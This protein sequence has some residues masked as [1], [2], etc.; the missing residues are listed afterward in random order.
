MGK[1]LFISCT[2]VG[3]AM[4]NEI[5][6]YEDIKETKVVGVV[7]L[8][9]RRGVHK[10]NYHSYFDIQNDYNIPVYYCNNVNDED[11]IQFM[12]N[13]NPDIIIQSGWSQKFSS[14]VLDIPRYKCIGEHPSPLPK[15]R[16]AACLNWAIINNETLW[17][18]SFF[19]MVDEYD[20]GELYAHR[21]FEI[22]KHDYIKTVYD[23]VAMTSSKI[24]AKKID[25][26]SSGDFLLSQQNELE[27]TYFTRR[28]PED[29]RFDFS[30]SAESIH[31]FIRAQAPPYPGAFFAFEGRK[32]SVISSRIVQIKDE[33]FSCGQIIS[34]T[35]EDGIIVSSANG[36]ALELIR[37]K[38]SYKPEQWASDWLDSL[39]EKPT[40]L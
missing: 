32:I 2:N 19:E 33:H 22:K 8:N 6:N 37:I 20:K 15:G 27:T 38:D 9:S 31:N 29:G 36:S 7:N 13:K 11:T 10:A 18:D 30:N 23:K 12:R 21:L 17:G 14:K 26:W 16:G 1:V 25:S 34:T 39:I 28:T 4:I 40:S 24:I 35:A 5:M 3:V